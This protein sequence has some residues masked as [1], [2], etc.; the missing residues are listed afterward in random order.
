[1]LGYEYDATLVK[2]F[3]CL[4]DVTEQQSLSVHNSSPLS[5]RC[6]RELS[7]KPLVTRLLPIIVSTVSSP[8]HGHGRA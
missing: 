1:M 2:H 6:S 3:G 4:H 5:L 8:Q 7:V